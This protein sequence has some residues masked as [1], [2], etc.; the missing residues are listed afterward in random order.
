MVSFPQVFWL[1]FYEY[2]HFY[3]FYMF[4][5]SHPVIML[6]EGLTILASEGSQSRQTA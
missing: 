3:A 5:P 4:G 1:N 6:R 2:M